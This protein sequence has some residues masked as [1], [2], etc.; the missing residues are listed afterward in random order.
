[1][2]VDD[3]PEGSKRRE[4][5][6]VGK[7][8][9]DISSGDGDDRVG[10]AVVGE[11]VEGHGRAGQGAGFGAVAVVGDGSGCGKRDGTRLDGECIC[12]S[13]DGSEGE[14]C[15]I[16]V[17]EEVEGRGRVGYGVE[18]GNVVVAGSGADGG[19]EGRTRLDGE[20]AR[21]GDEEDD[22]DRGEGEEAL[23][24]LGGS[25]AIAAAFNRNGMR[26][27]KPAPGDPGGLAASKPIARA[28]E[29]EEF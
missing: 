10:C 7:V 8:V 27:S 13:D 16:D 11:E 20:S 18:G 14:D 2:V 26:L 6:L 4:M 22:S 9:H 24:V 29:G 23:E 19:R 15:A 28:R 3:G 5:W 25:Q 12:G 21:G 17:G 1:M